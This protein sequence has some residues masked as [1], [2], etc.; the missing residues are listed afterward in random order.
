MLEVVTDFAPMPIFVYEADRFK[1]LD[2]LEKEINKKIKYEEKRAD[3]K[4]AKKDKLIADLDK[5]LE[6]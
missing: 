5:Y 3:K 6:K 1:D 2:A 4:K